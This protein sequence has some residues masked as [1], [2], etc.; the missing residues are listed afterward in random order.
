[1]KHHLMIGTW[2]PPGVIITVEFDDE[3][4]SL[5]LVKKT[6]IPQDE[7]ISWMTFDH[8]RKNIYGASMKKWSSHEVKSPEE[9]VH[10]SSHPMSHDPKAAQADTRTRAIFVLA[11]QQPPYCVY[12]NPFY[13][14]AGFG[15]VFSVHDDGSLKASIQNYA[16]SPESAIHGMVFDPTETYLYSA[17]MWANRIWCHKKSVFGTVELVGY[18]EAPA[19]KDHPRWVEMHPGGKYLYALMEAG[20]QICEYVI[21]ERT[22]LP[23]YTHKSYPLIPPDIPNPHLY[24]SDVVFLSSSSQ[25]LFATSRSNKPDLLTGYIAAFSISPDGHIVSQHCLNPTPTSGGHSNA[26]IP[27]PWSDEWLALTDDEK[28]GVEIYRWHKGFLGRVARLEV[29]EKGF[30]M[31]AIWY[32]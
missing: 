21:D 2:T 13:E 20:N 11:A 29:A 1:M 3:A 7:P 10:S 30:G 32:D 22:H 12:G 17:D 25:T 23:V 5:K 8:K 14:H 15:N 9:I 16:Y 27:C 18:T 6:E 31:N 28:G 4:L 19:K 24:R 26:V